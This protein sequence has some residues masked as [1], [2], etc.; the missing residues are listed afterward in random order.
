MDIRVIESRGEIGDPKC[1][2]DASCNALCSS[3]VGEIS[4]LLQL[5][6]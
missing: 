6:P 1:L 2:V 4:A 3:F 5:Q